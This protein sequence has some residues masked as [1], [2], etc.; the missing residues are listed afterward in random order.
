M[1]SEKDLLYTIRKLILKEYEETRL[2]RSLLNVTMFLT[3]DSDTHV[4]DTLTRI[5][6]LP[7]VSVVGQGSP[8]N[9]EH[10]GTARLECY[11]KFLPNSSD[12]YKN[13]MGIAELIKSLP[14]VRM[15]KI[16]TLGGNKVLFKG[17]SIVV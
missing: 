5:R 11:V 10:A 2:D 6:V 3:M 4:P 7:T 12:T 16:L 1:S 15:V 17:R 8:V 13:L 9:R 14:G